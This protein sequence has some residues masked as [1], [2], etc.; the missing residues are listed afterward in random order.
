MLDI[1]S[2]KRDRLFFEQ[3]RGL[4]SVLGYEVP[5]LRRGVP[6]VLKGALGF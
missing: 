5:Q 3:T 6:K 2:S 1:S 4:V